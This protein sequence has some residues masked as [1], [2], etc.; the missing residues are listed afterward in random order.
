MTKILPHDP[1]NPFIQK[2]TTWF[3]FDLFCRE[4]EIRIS[5]AAL[6]QTLLSVVV[7]EGDSTGYWI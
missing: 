2:K 6:T 4:E 1:K 7:A 3:V 5:P